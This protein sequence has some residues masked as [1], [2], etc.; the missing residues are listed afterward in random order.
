MHDARHQRTPRIAAALL[1]ALGCDASKKPPVADGTADLSRAVSLARAV[2][3]TGKM[4][5]R[6]READSYTDNATYVEESVI[7]SEGVPRELPFFEMSVAFARPNRVRVAF[8]EA[9]PTVKGSEK[10]FE[11]ACDGE[12][13]RAA[14]PEIPDQMVENPAPAALDSSNVLP[15]PLIVAK[16]SNRPLSEVFPQLAMLLN[17]SDDDD[18]AVFPHDSNPRMLA[19]DKLNG[20]KCYRVATSNPEGT[21]VLWIDRETYDLHRMELPV[22]SY[23]RQ[24]DPERMYL[25][26]SVRIDFKNSTFDARIDK[27][28][29][30]MDP[31]P[32]IRRVRRFVLPEEDETAKDAE[33]AKEEQSEREDGD[34]SEAVGDETAGDGQEE[35]IAEETEE[36]AEPENGAATTTTQRHAEEAGGAESQ[37]EQN[38]EGNADEPI[39]TAT[40]E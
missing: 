3:I 19:D 32:G 28:S 34:G 21:R 4:L 7:R 39:E 20:R 1:L 35:E 9:V 23:R 16:L 10:G 26:F 2:E 5:A 38:E 31:K 33:S 24:M 36:D 14:L 11:F 6:Y 40:D 15:D 37:N 30:V 17:T 25:Q 8:S 27:E 29:F 18:A 22:E 13:M 12:L